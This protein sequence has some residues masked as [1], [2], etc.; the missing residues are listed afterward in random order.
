MVG[1][2]WTSSTAA[3]QIEFKA[4]VYATVYLGLRIGE[5]MLGATTWATTVIQ[6]F[7]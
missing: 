4:R 3:S 1:N 5:V 6:S 2:S 7:D